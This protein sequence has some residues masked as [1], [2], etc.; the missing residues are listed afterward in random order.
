MNYFN[1][2]TERL[3]FRK[4]TREDIPVW[5][6][7]F[8][9]NDRLRFLGIDLSNKPETH[10][11]EWIEKQLERYET[12]GLGHLAIELKETSE[13]IGVGGIIP[14]ELENKNEFEIAYSLLPKFWNNGYGTELAKKMTK[15]GFEN[16]KPERFVSIIDKENS[17]SINVAL[18]NGMKVLFETQYL[19]M[20][21][22][23][24]GIYNE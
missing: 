11:T 23:V 16:I 22:E 10:A 7:F 17:D 4:L 9:N 19:G 20:N 5:T 14:R 12:E 24:Y 2:Q 15:Y 13:F 3:K 1:Q 6:S 8:V 18:K 21:V